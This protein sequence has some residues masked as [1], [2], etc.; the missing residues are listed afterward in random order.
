MKK[1]ITVVFLAMIGWINGQENLSYQQPSA[2]ILKLADYQ[3]PPSVSM[4]SKRE[5]MIFSYRDT[6]KSL[7][8]LNQQE[9]RLGGLR[10][11]PVTNIS[12]S[13]TYITNLKKKLK[14]RFPQKQK[15]LTKKQAI[16]FKKLS[17]LNKLSQNLKTLVGNLCNFLFQ[18]QML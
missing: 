12:S 16:L 15:K 13:L 8:E 10:I 11:N 4:D 18:L 2:E 1:T 6:Y 3:R 17:K 9:M 14:K 5:W 7:D